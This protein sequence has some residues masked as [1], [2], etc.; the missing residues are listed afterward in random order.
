MKVVLVQDWLIHMRGGEKVLEA[1]A[2]IYPDAPIYTLFYNRSG[3]SPVLKNRQIIPSFLH[4]LPGIRRYYRW[5]LPFLPFAVRTL[6]IPAA[7]LVFSTSH[8]VAKGVR[9]PKGA[10]HLCYCHTPMRYLYGF[11]ED[12]FGKM[13]FVLKPFINL[14]LSALKAWDLKSN[15]GVDHFIANSENVRKRILKYYARASEVIHPPV[16]SDFYTAAGNQ[17][18]DYYLVVSA[19]VPY[20]RIDLVIEAFNTLDRS[21]LIVGSGPM[22]EAYRS[23]RTSTKISFLGSVP[24]KELHALLTEAKALIFPTEE[25]FGIVPLEAQACGTPVIAYGKGGAL[26]SVKTGLFFEEQ[27]A[28]SLRNA[29]EQFETRSFDR[30]EIPAKISDFSKARFKEKI[31]AFAR[32]HTEKGVTVLGNAQ[33]STA[34]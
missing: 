32:Q 31:R 17:P 30:N 27:T 34:S 23:I 33:I 18:K 9:V 4:Y 3:L 28:Q 10:L 19:F 2:E 5:L 13:P 16:N 24:D 1:L 11:G 6:K 8:C 20:K 26:E 14:V 7:D 25:D 22:D 29:V 15:A 12:Y 21:L